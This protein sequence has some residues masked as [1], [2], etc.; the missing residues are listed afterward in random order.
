LSG[1]ERREVV[2]VRGGGFAEPCKLITPTNDVKFSK[3][4]IKP[5]N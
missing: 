4:S 2:A 1:V 5:E 3:L